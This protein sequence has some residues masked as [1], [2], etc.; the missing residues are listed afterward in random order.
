MLDFQPVNMGLKTLVE[1]YTFKYGEGSCQHS[2][3]SSYCLR[4][5]YGDMFCEHDNFLYTLRSRK[6]TDSERVY[7]FPHG[8]RSNPDAL[9]QAV[10]NVLNDSHEHGARVKFETL[11]ASAKDIVMNM[12][13][14]KFEE[15]AD[16]D[17]YEYLYLT[18]NLLN[19]PGHEFATKRKNIHKFFRDY[20]GRYEVL[21][22]APE[23]IDLIREFQTKWLDAKVFGEDDFIH[24]HQLEQENEAIQS[25][26]DDFFALG[27]SGVVMFIDGA[28]S[29]YAY[30]APLSDRVFDAI[31]EKGDRNIPSVY[32][33]IKHEF[34]RLCCEGYEYVNLEEDV[35]VEGLRTMKMRYK[36]EY[37]LEKFIVREK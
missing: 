7:L 19:L 36:P 3:V 15:Q 14:G 28:L 8:D 29:G 10:Q 33:V 27:M 6:C 26:L 11:T 32:R 37:M 35:G 1:S 25:C 24:E 30:G 2:F 4:H 21:K 34:T 5:K 16:R 23:H 12:F 13:P 17:L 9:R 20:E 22:I 18:D 31:V